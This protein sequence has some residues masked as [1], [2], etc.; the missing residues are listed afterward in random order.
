MLVSCQYARSRTFCNPVSLNSLG[1]AVP[2]LWRLAAATL[3]KTA[4]AVRPGSEIGSYTGLKKLGV[5]LSL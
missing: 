1:T 2:G 3:L 5:E 4:I